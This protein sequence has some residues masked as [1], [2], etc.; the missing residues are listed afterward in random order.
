MSLR[1]VLYAL[2]VA[3][4]GCQAYSSAPDEQYAVL[5]EPTA[6]TRAELLMVV[7][8]ALGGAP[9]VLASD[10]LTATSLLSVE[11]NPRRRLSG[12]PLDGRVLGGPEQ[13]RLVLTHAGCELIR[14]STGDRFGLEHAR[15]VP[16]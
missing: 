4:A 2:V 10:A 14:L 12:G 1:N 6:E 9:V 16:E 11:I 15:C 13:F 8:R 3:A 7:T 5:V